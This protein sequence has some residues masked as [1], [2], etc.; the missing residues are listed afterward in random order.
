MLAY[1]F[2]LLIGAQGL[3]AV[4]RALRDWLYPRV[5]A[6]PESGGQERIAHDILPPV[7]KPSWLRRWLVP[8]LALGLLLLATL[9]P[10][11]LATADAHPHGSAYWNELIGGVPGAAQAGMM[12]QFWG[13]STRDALDQVNRRASRGAAVY[14]HDAAWGAFQMYQREGWLRR[15]VR[16][17]SDAGDSAQLG[18]IHHGKDL[19]DYELDMMRNFKWRTP[20][21]QSSVDGVPI[22]SLY[23]RLPEPPAEPG[24]R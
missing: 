1:P 23:Q 17:T 13:G 15:D 8:Q 20:V 9:G 11:A 12:R 16:F 2:M 14:F 19:D 18:I 22:V 7:D 24:H 21:L 4:W 10:A 3:Q 6:S 5:A